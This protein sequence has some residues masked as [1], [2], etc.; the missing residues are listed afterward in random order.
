MQ[1]FELTRADLLDT[2]LVERIMRRA[3]ATNNLFI[4]PYDENRERFRQIV[5]SGG[6]YRIL[7]GVEDD[8]ICALALLV[9]P[10]LADDNPAQVAHFYNEGSSRLRG[11]M[12]DAIV[13][14][15]RENGHMKV[16]A[17]NHTGAPDSVWGRMFRRAGR[18]S[19]VGSIMEVRWDGEETAGE[20]EQ[21]DAPAQE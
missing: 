6:Y 2:Y 18:I 8:D 7:L 1:V 3:F 4:G 5:E 12:V 9:L 13:E 21:A 14:L 19:K 11:K 16:W 20:E 15:L 10:D 17:I